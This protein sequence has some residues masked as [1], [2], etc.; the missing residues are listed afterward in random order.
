MKSTGDLW[1]ILM[2]NNV[3]ATLVLLSVIPFPHYLEFDSH[4]L[5]FLFLSGACWVLAASFD[6]KSHTYLDA[7]VGSILSSIRYVLLTL[8]GVLL[9]KED[10]AWLGAGGVALILIS[11]A[12]M[13]DFSSL[14]FRKG[15]FF[16][17][18]AVVFA[19]VA[20]ITDKYLTGLVDIEV[21]VFTAFFLPGTFYV[22]SRPLK[23]QAMVSEVVQSRGKMI[24]T[25]I[26]LAAMYYC[27]A[28]AF[29]EG[30]L[31]VTIAIAQTTVVVVFIFGVLFLKERDRLFMR[32]FSSILC[33]LGAILV[34]I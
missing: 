25:P 10:I 19:G 27:Y 16:K 21:V 17:I 14:T 6:L 3:G 15:A 22:L 26:G 9:F 30:E 8:V 20:L 29:G 28:H 7:S 11:V 31:T 32:A 4:V 2:L 24:L 34:S 12:M 18:L 23:V 1:G 13:I 33:V 5:M